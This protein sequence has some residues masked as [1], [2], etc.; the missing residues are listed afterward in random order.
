MP[1]ELSSSKGLDTLTLGDST[2]S[3]VPKCVSAEGLMVADEDQSC[4]ADQQKPLK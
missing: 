1:H 2:S 4:P 3:P